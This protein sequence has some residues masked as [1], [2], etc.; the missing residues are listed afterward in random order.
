MLCSLFEFAV[1]RRYREASAPDPTVFVNKNREHSGMRS[2]VVGRPRSAQ[3]PGTFRAVLLAVLWITAAPCSQAPPAV[4]GATRLG[5]MEMTSSEFQEASR[6]PG[7]VAEPDG[8]IGCVEAV[9]GRIVCLD[10][11]TGEQLAWSDAPMRPLLLRNGRLVA[12]AVSPDRSNVVQPLVGEITTGEFAPR[13]L[14][15]VELPDWT[16]PVHDDPGQFTLDATIQGELLVLRWEAHSRYEGGAGPPEFLEEAA[17]NDAGGLVSIDLG[18]GA[19]LGAEPCEVSLDPDPAL[20]ELVQTFPMMPYKS[21]A[22]WLNEPWRA[23]AVEALLLSESAGGESGLY[24]RHRDPASR[25]YGVEHRLSERL[26]LEA[27]VTPDGRFVFLNFPETAGKGET[28]ANWHLFSAE[29][30]EPLAVLPFEIGTEEVAVAGPRI[31][32]LLS[33]ELWDETTGT[34]RLR[35]KLKA[36]DLEGGEEQWSLLLS[37]EELAPEMP[38]PPMGAPGY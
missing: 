25:Q 33:E 5:G 20:V 23:G 18:S 37:E 3:D 6:I 29:S 36:R 1:R 19:V 13:G 26:D 17:T 15:P 38:P 14:E 9:G 27:A 24:L 10:L 28:G 22:S 7:G 30:G 16:D 8:S 4:G 11:A 21:G 12:W 2:G 34:T 35:R 32:Y 31:L